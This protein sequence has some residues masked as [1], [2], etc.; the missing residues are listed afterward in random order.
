MSAAELRKLLDQY[1]ISA[2][3]CVEKGDLIDRAKQAWDQV[4]KARAAKAAECES[5]CGVVILRAG[6]PLDSV[7]VFLMKLLEQVQYCADFDHCVLHKV[8][9]VCAFS[10]YNL[11]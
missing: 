1:G 7:L 2:T 5:I 3:G 9:K 10:R 11:L 6:H 4:C 8:L